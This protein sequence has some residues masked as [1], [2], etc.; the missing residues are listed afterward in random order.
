MNDNEKAIGNLPPYLWQVWTM[1]QSLEGSLVLENLIMI[2]GATQSMWLAEWKLQECLEKFRCLSISV[3]IWS[4][5]VLEFVYWGNQ[6]GDAY[7]LI[8]TSMLNSKLKILIKIFAMSLP[9][10][11]YQVYLTKQRKVSLVLGVPNSGTTKFHSR[12][13]IVS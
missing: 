1:D 3:F 9:L 4:Q 6:S 2:Y 11:N 12:N 10:L 8:V 7:V 13:F 5:A